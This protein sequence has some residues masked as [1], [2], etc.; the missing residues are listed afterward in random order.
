MDL[1]HLRNMLAVIEEGSLGKAAQRL[2]ISQPALTKSIQRLEEHLGV[3]LFERVSRG[4]KPTFY[5]Q[6][7][8]G[9][10]KA[11][12]VGM[13]EAQSRI[14]SLRNGTEGLITVAAPPQIATELLPRLLVRLA[15]ERPKLHVRIVSQNKD[16]FLDLLDGHFDVV[17]AMMYN[18]FPNEGLEREWLFD[19]KLVLAMRADHPLSEKANLRPED[20]LDQKWVF[21]DSNTW[22][23]HRLRLYFEQ[24]GLPVPVAQMECRDP[25]VLKAVVST[26]DYISVIANLGIEREVKRGVLRAMEIPSPLMQRPIGII[27]RSGEQMSPAIKSFV[28]IAQDMC[29][30]HAVAAH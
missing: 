14:A 23:Q 29:G 19:D 16:L 24:L 8:Q 20:L 2:N 28:Q 18:E 26:S 27:R 21:A 11:A 9:Y 25:A 13:A 6:S 4:M 22:N 30:T 15:R 1:R 7:L 10:A 12:C 17:I 5:A 3:K